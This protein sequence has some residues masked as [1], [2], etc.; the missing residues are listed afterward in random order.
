MATPYW[1]EVSFSWP[2]LSLAETADSPQMKEIL[3]FIGESD[4]A[5]QARLEKM[6]WPERN[7]E[8]RRRYG[9]DDR[10]PDRIW[11]DFRRIVPPPKEETP[12]WEDALFAYEVDEDDPHSVEDYVERAWLETNWGCS[13]N[14]MTEVGGW[15]PHQRTLVFETYHGAA[16]PVFA[17]LHRKFPDVTILYNWRGPGDGLQGGCEFLSRIDWDE[18]AVSARDHWL[19]ERGLKERGE[20]PKLV[21]EAGKPYNEWEI[22]L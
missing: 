17:A 18:N 6:G 22:Q 4:E 10:Q 13:S 3:D 16:I 8:F 20:I 14:A 2:G 21:W 12:P 1:N 15:Y 9:Y 5:Y 7:A 19:I 11:V